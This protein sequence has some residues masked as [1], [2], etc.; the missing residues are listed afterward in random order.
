VKILGLNE[1]EVA[2]AVTQGCVTIAIYGLDRLM[3]LE[4]LEG[5]RV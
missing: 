4:C 2:K 5:L 1:N 3:F